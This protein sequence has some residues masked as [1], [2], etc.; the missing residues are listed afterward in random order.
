MPVRLHNY[1][2]A[3]KESPPAE[4]GAAKSDLTGAERAALETSI[5]ETNRAFAHLTF[6]HDPANQYARGRGTSA[7]VRGQVRRIQKFGEVVIEL[8]NRHTTG[9][10]T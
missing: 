7:Y 6:W 5:N 3:Q 4:Q 1:A 8:Y 10:P 9:L 2:E